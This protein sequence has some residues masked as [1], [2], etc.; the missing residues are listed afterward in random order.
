MSSPED[1]DHQLTV[2][3][4]QLP[5]LRRMYRGPVGA[6]RRLAIDRA[7]TAARAGEPIEEHLAAL[8]LP[9]APAPRGTQEDEPRSSLPTRVTDAAP[10]ALL[11]DHV[12]PRG[13]CARREQRSADAQRPVCEVFDL[14]LRFEAED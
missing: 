5:R 1:H 11:G 4:Q 12:C 13:V 7:V 8:G 10:R 9:Q 2:F 14:A 6:A 3:C